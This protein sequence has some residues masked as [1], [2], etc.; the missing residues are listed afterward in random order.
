[1]IPEVDIAI[2]GPYNRPLL[3]APQVHNLPATYN[4]PPNYL[5]VTASDDYQL[6]FRRATQQEMTFFILEEVTSRQLW[7]LFRLRLSLIVLLFISNKNI[8]ILQFLV[9]GKCPKVNLVTADG[10]EL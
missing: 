5:I 3:I 6:A 7:L 4:L 9:L 8:V 10:S 1:M 2:T